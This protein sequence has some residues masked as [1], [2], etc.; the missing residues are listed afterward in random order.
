[1]ATS[2]Q[3]L[4]LMLET[5]VPTAPALST[6]S[7]SPPPLPPG[8]TIL[9]ARQLAAAGSDVTVAAAWHDVISD[10]FG[11]FVTGWSPERFD[12][13]FMQ[14]IHYL[15]E[16]L[17][18]AV[19]E[20][21]RVVGTCLGWHHSGAPT[22]VGRLHWLAVANDHKGKGIGAALIC[23]VLGYY[24]QHRHFARVYLTT[25]DFRANA[26]H[27]YH[28]FGFRSIPEAAVLEGNANP[29]VKGTHLTELCA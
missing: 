28:R 25:E 15:P 13:E 14:N 22:T 21:G 11:E 5:P 24:H 3:K 7:S 17:F 19:T 23:T 2:Y 9:N 27:L 4:F 12:T 6:S 8:Y 26:I 16:A 29:E 1:M 18:F 10:A 20:G